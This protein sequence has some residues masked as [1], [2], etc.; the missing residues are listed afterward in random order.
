MDKNILITGGAG[1][2]GSNTANKLYGLGYKVHT[3]DNYLLGTKLNLKEKLWETHKYMDCRD[4]ND[5]VQEY[6]DI[7]CV[8]HLGNPSSAPMFNE[9]L[10]SFKN[11]IDGFDSVLKFCKN[12][13]AKLIFASTSSIM[14]PETQY[15]LSREIM[16]FMAE[17]SNVDYIGFRF[18]SVY[19][20]NETHKGKYANCLTQ[21]LWDMFDGNPPIIYGDGTQTRD[22][23]HVFDIVRAIRKAIDVVDKKNGYILHLGT[24]E[25]TSFNEIVSELMEALKGWKEKYGRDTPTPEYVDNPIDKYVQHT[26]ADKKE[27]EKTNRIIDWEPRIGIKQGIKMQVEEY[28]FR[29]I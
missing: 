26:K 11:V 8:I 12:I 4:L 14:G 3:I 22:F 18:Y 29:N 7:D 20:P 24:G 1:F 17:K 25:S 6:E 23:I 5:F 13:D 21:F 28:D 10:N 15:S 16:E 9:D 27:L 2:I 19:G